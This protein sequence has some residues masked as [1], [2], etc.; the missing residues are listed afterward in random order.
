VASN[1]MII[2]GAAGTLAVAF[3]QAVE[4]SCDGLFLFD[5]NADERCNIGPCD[6]SNEDSIASAA[7]TIEVGRH[8]Y[9]RLLIASGAF[10]GSADPELH[11]PRLQLSLQTNL[12]GVT[13]LVCV[14]IQGVLDNGKR[15]RI[16]VVTSAAAQVGS[17]DLGYGIAKA[18]LRGLVRSVSKSY[19]TRGITALGVEPGLFPSRMSATQDRRRYDQA[20][21][22]SHLGRITS[23]SEVVS[24]VKF[25]MVDAPDALTGTFV[26]PNGGQI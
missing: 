16:V 20:A 15:A 2:V 11:W 14:F 5:R 21:A 10:D 19:G 8:D 22:S 6:L 4:D 17:R 23:L 13:Q 1:G 7:A 3:R 26:S 24:C 18:G 9:W 25:A 12:I